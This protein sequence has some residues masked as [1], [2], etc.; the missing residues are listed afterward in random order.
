MELLTLFRVLSHIMKG[1]TGTR[2]CENHSPHVSVS[3]P[4][5]PPLQGSAAV[6]RAGMVPAPQLFG[7]L[8]EPWTLWSVD[9]LLPDFI[10]SVAFLP[11]PPAVTAA[12]RLTGVGAGALAILWASPA[13]RCRPGPCAL[14]T[15]PV[16]SLQT[17][18]QQIGH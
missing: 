8:W 14:R 10:F 11:T 4:P 9:F 6:T 15:L 7:G 16:F 13:P 1:L 2:L 3:P 18:Q 12:Q 5:P 17:R